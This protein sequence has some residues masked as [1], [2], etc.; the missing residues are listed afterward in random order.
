MNTLLQLYKSNSTKCVEMMFSVSLL[1]IVSLGWAQNSP[2]DDSSSNYNPS[3]HSTVSRWDYQWGK[4]K[5]WTSTKLTWIYMEQLHDPRG[6]SW[7]A[8]N[9]PRK[10][11]F[12]SDFGYLSH[13]SLKSNMIIASIYINSSLLIHF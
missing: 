5:S 13:I 7:R 6:E 1:C 12:L 9:G 3:Y 11:L 4:D 2:Y 10:K 8:L